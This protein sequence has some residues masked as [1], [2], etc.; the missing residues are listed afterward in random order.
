MRRM[1][2]MGWVIVYALVLV[3]VGHGCKAWDYA[4]THMPPVTIGGGAA[5][6]VQTPATSSGGGTAATVQVTTTTTTTAA[7][8]V[9]VYGPENFG[10]KGKE[11][12]KPAGA[13]HGMDVRLSCNAAGDLPGFPIAGKFYNLDPAVVYGAEAIPNADWTITLRARDFTSGRTGQKYYFLGFKISSAKA[14]LIEQNNYTVPKGTKGSIR[15]MYAT[16]K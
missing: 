2:L 16:G 11:I 10:D 5:T 15:F 6:T 1:Y 9:R 3:V 4:V 14:P 8:V 13:C 7:P 12:W